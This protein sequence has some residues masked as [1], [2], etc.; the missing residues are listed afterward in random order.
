MM[1]DIP[2]YFKYWGKA[3]KDGSR[4]H[5]LPYHC[6]DVAAVA[7]AWWDQSPAIR[8]ELKV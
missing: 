8:H 1:E 2:N 6:L 5:L 7:A 3:E 4:Y